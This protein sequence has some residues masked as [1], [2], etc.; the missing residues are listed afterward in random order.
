MPITQQYEAQQLF[1]LGRVALRWGLSRDTVRRLVSGGE[2]R[3]VMIASR[4]LI[5]L[6]EI[7]RA[8]RLG[9]GIPR[10]HRAE[11]LQQV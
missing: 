7:E 1:S 3:S 5:P 2:L 8:E 10:K 11:N 6:V 9:V 4:R